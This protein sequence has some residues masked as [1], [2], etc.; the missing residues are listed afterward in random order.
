M[1]LGESAT[2]PVQSQLEPS[3]TEFSAPGDLAAFFNREGEMKPADFAYLCAAYHFSEYG[4]GPFS[5]VE[6][7][8][9]AAEAG[10]IVPDRLDMTYT[11]AGKKGKKLF[12]NLGKG[13][14]KPTA[15]GSIE[16]KERWGVKPG[17]KTK[18]PTTGSIE[19]Q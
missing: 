13:I 9:I 17:R 7:R 15:T 6:I 5:V 11:S 2:P 1:L 14:F 3:N 18:A 19:V 8:A 12:Q 4:T 10:V 16:F